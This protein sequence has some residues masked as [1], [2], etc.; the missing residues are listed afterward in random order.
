MGIAVDINEQREL[1]RQLEMC[2]AAA[3]Q[4]ANRVRLG[5][6]YNPYGVAE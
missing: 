5:G 2:R 1:F 4:N 6:Y 3:L